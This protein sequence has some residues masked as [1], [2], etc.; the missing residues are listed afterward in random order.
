MDVFCIAL[1]IPVII[2][3]WEQSEVSAAN[4]IER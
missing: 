3:D 1:L 4:R 2:C